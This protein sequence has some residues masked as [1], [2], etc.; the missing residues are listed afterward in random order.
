MIFTAVRLY[1][2]YNLDITDI[3]Y[4]SIGSTI[5]GVIQLGIAVMVAS[6]PLLR[7]VFDRTIGSWLKLS[8]MR[9]KKH[10]DA[11]V[12]AEDGDHPLTIGRLR[13]RDRPVRPMNESEENLQWE[14][15]AMGH[16]GYE[17]RVTV[18]GSS[19]Y[20]ESDGSNRPGE[21]VV[22]KSTTVL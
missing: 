20:Q 21:I 9:S 8:S 14:L 18:H 4:S 6:S 5:I 3:T 17:R 19:T 7:P 15:T 12:Q 10:Y 16:K 1:F 22:T 11:H 13:Q 2:V